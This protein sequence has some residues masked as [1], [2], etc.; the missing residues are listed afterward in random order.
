MEGSGWEISGGLVNAY[1]TRLWM[2]VNSPDH[3]PHSLGQGYTPSPL[4]ALSDS[5]LEGR[6]IVAHGE[7]SEPWGTLKRRT[8]AQLYISQ[9]LISAHQR[10]FLELTLF[11]SRNG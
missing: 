1:P 5:A 2:N 6:R 11:S 7:R 9:S 10:L 3:G 8:L 4:P